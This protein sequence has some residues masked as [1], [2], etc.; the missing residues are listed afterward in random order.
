M[1]V[2]IVS[3]CH[4]N[5]L[6]QTQRILDQFAERKGDRTWQTAITAQGLDTLRRLLKK[7][8]RKNTAVACHW[9]RGKDYS[10]LLWIVG[11]TSQFSPRGT[12]PTNTTQRDILR[13]YD[14]NDWHSAEEIHLLAAIAALFHDFGKANSTFQ[15]KLSSKKAIADPLRHEWVSLRLFEAFVGDDDDQ[16]WVRRLAELPDS[17][18]VEWVDRVIRDGEGERNLSP[19]KKLKP[20]ARAVAWLIISHHRLPTKLIGSNEPKLKTLQ[21]LPGGIN[22]DWCGSHISTDGLNANEL[23]QKV[24]LIRGCWQFKQPVPFTV[25]AWK[26]RVRKQAQRILSRPKLF[27]ESWLSGNTYVL[28]V[29]RL[30]LMLADHHYSSLTD[31]KLREKV[32]PGY[33]LIANTLR[34]TGEPN[35]TL[36]E[37]LIGVERHAGRIAHALTRM[38]RQFPSITRHKGFTRRSSNPF[39]QWQN[40]AFE[41]GTVL[42]QKS[43]EQGFFGINMAS[44]G[45]GKTLANGRIMYG[46][47][48]Q[49]YGAR[50]TIALGLRTL[51]LQTGEAYRH[52]LGLGADDLSILVGGHRVR[53]L[54]EHNESVKAQQEQDRL[55]HNG[56][57]SMQSLLP[58]GSHVYYEGSLD[59]GPLSAWIDK[60]KGVSSLLSAPILTCTIDHLMPATESTRGGHQIAPMLRLMTSDL[61]LDEPDDFGVED[62]PALTRLVHWAGLLGSR[63]LLSSAT[64]PPSI[65][66]G[67]FEAYA[68]GRRLY[69]MNR[70]KPGQALNICTAW[71]DEFGVHSDEHS[72]PD[73]FMEAHNDWVKKRV[74]ALSKVH[75]VRRLAHI[76]PVPIAAGTDEDELNRTFASLLL[77][78]SISLHKHHYAVDPQTEKKVSFGLIRMANINPLVQVTRALA[79]L[80]VE[81]DYRLHLCCYHSRHPMIMR[82]NIERRLDFFLNRQDPNRIF[83]SHD[84]RSTLNRHPESNHLFIVLAT[85]VAEVGRDHDYDWAIVEPSSMRSI[86]QLAGRVRR[87]RSGSVETSNI[88]LLDTNIR[89]LHHPIG[90]ATYCKPGFEQADHFLL[91]NSHALSDIL[92]A[93]QV[94]AIDSRPRVMERSDPKPRTNLVDLEHDHLR[95]IMIGDSSETNRKL[96][97]NNWWRTRSHLSGELQRMQPFRYD[98]EGRERYVFL[99][100][101]DSGEETFNRFEMDGSLT[102]VENLRQQM[103]FE[104]AS[105]IS[106]WG[107]TN[108]SRQLEELAEAMEISPTECSVRF[109]TLELPKRGYEQG[110]RYHP[111]LGMSR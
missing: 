9:I 67:L 75:E 81:L 92:T 31:F 107:E 95:A 71:F 69:Q 44:T 41:L 109:G 24:A 111:A 20:L 32:P 50:F 64:L 91:Q 104:C 36:D 77:D 27:D 33:P 8:A 13:K 85:A 99:Y 73:P 94:A 90:K 103:S 66:Q 47:S 100:D 88:H 12:V 74:M 2:L 56:A 61:V 46:L 37:H 19:F 106:I 35:Q 93:E 102:P 25:D 98:P 39:F 65:V 45:R 58:D 3:Q 97:A 89:S 59:E 38:E 57:E 78:Q 54:H 72:E 29:S 82:S 42:R 23:K 48:D 70:G 40:K 4:K 83:D 105:N 79:Q 110:W 43:K 14:E 26:K 76:S 7:S 15:K 101:E 18:N 68:E 49:A 84:L 51:T 21:N 1:N 55:E 28:H 87:H 52:Q 62:L 22:E 11:N 80:D 17:P 5:A 53:E 34:D 96:A 86:I 60:T 63:I 30:V 16:E 108:Y 6:R 10:E